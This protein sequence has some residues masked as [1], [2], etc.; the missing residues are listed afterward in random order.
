MA[1]LQSDEANIL[2]AET[3]NWRVIVYPILAVLIV[4]VGGFGYY[5]YLQSQ[6][7]DLE[8]SARAAF[9]EAKT[10]EEMAKV[11]DQFPGADQATVALLAAADASFAKQDYDAAI[12]NYQRIVQTVTSDPA[13]RDSAQ[14]GLASAQESSGK[15][16]EAIHTYVAVG[17]E[18]VKSPYAPYAYFSASLRAAR[19]Q[20]QRA[21]HSD[22]GGRP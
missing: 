12:K 18:G 15:I 3:I 20:G 16:D 9:V 14:L 2:D 13:L 11:A 5:Y 6:R 8:A 22:R 19:R 1:T 17:Q 21:E 7:E 10:P 4:T